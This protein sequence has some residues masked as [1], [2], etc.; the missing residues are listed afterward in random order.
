MPPGRRL[1]QD[2]P[3]AGR[4]GCGLWRQGDI[5]ISEACPKPGDMVSSTKIIKVVWRQS[6]D[7]LNSLPEDTRQ[8]ERRQATILFADISGFTAL[9]EAP[10]PEI[11]SDG[12]AN[13]DS[14]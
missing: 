2:L 9:S 13:P 6:V 14:H 7:S 1:L 5:K 3:S 4:P 8:G 12:V 11:V 10:E